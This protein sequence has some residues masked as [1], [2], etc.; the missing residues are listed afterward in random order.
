[1]PQPFIRQAGL[2]KDEKVNVSIEGGRIILSKEKP[3]L[4][5]LL[6]FQACIAPAARF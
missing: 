5:K 3:D 6:K 1:M 2:S 4:K